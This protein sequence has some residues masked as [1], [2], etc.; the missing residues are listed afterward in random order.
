MMV[1]YILAIVVSELSKLLSPIIQKLVKEKTN[2]V[3]RIIQSLIP[4]K[5]VKI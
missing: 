3:K 2:Q 1:D 5:L 4:T